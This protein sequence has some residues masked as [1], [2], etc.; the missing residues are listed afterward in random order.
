MTFYCFVVFIK[1]THIS[2]GVHI[3]VTSISINNHSNTSL[4]LWDREQFSIQNVDHP[5]QTDKGYQDETL[6]KTSLATI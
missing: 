2:K 4:K 5:N 6:I 3:I 1:L